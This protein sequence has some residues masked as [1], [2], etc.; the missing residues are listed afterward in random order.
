MVVELAITNASDKNA[1]FTMS[2]KNV[3]V[4]ANWSYSGG[5]GRSSSS[6]TN[7]TLSDSKAEFDKNESDDLKVTLRSGSY[8]LKSIKNGSYTLEEG[9]DYTIS[10]GTVIIKASYLDSLKEG[11]HSLTF[12]MNGGTD[13]VLTIIVSETTIVTDTTETDTQEEKPPVE[14]TAKFEDVKSGDWFYDAVNYINKAGLMVVVGTS[15]TTFSLIL[16]QQEG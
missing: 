1:S 3:T 2:A 6:S 14:E 5:G 8:T 15:D 16:I 7:A 11:K 9:K 4:T 13:P 12:D 10:G